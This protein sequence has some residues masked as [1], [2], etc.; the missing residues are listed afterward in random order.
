MDIDH[1]DSAAP[2]PNGDSL[3][4]APVAPVFLKKRLYCTLVDTVTS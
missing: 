1:L 2:W 3:I 4:L